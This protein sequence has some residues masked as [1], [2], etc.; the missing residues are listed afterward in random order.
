[1]KIYVVVSILEDN[2]PHHFLYENWPL[3]V[4]LVNNFSSEAD[5]AN[6]LRLLRDA[7]INQNV[8]TVSGKSMEKF[9]VNKDV[10]VTVLESTSEFETLRTNLLTALKDLTKPFGHQY[11][12]YRPHVADRHY[13]KIAIGEQVKIESISLVELIGNERQVISTIP[14]H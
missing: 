11:E 7:C 3:H 13:R 9:G 6:L 4:T 2:F 12:S 14:L 1:M 8:I 5:P 10:S